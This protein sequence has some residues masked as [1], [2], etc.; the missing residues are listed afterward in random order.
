MR[1]QGAV[2]LLTGATGFLGKVVLAELVRRRSELGI[3][4]V[5]LLVRAADAGLADGR[6]RREVVGSP[7][8]GNEAPGWEK[9]IEAVVGDL[10]QPGCGLAEVD[11]ARIAA[12][13]TH[14]IHCAASVAFDLPLPEA[15]QANTTAALSVLELAESCRR[16]ASVVS[17]STAYV[18]PHPGGEVHTVRETPAPLPRDPDELYAEVLDGTAREAAWLAESGHPNT[19]TFT[20]SLAEHLLL[21]RRRQAPLTLLRPSIISGSQR[22]PE[23]GWID[24]PAAFAAFVVLIAIGQLRAVAADPR[25]RLDLMPCDEVARRC[26]D[27]AFDPPEPASPRIEHAVAG[28]GAACSIQLCMERILAFFGRHPVM[29]G[30]RLRYVGPRG[31]RFAVE[32]ALRHRLPTAAAA[33]W[34][35]ATRQPR[36]ARAA[37]RLGERQSAINRDFAYFTH[38]TFDFRTVT[39]LGPDFDPSRYLDIACEGMHR[40]LLERRRPGG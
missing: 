32:H 21:R 16:I 6:L 29:G 11:R 1:G 9:S 5:R 38:N 34:L 31:P 19:Y 15:A 26:V 7:C 12:E 20:K 35:G 33:L 25:T 30:P 24:S 17:V 40:N 8:F 36:R 4:R 22:H 37:R 27:A 3:E 13:T 39:P 28:L 18:T 14:V 10:A 2:V 23:P